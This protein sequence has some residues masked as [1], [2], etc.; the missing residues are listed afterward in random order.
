M[1][2]VKSKNIATRRIP[3]R[4][5]FREKF[6]HKNCVAIGLSAG[7]VEPLEATALLL[8]EAT[9]KLLAEKLPANKAGIDYAQRS[10]NKITH[11]AWEAG[12]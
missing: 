1:L 3:M 4:I 9:A 6:W 7:F 10:F 12:Y 11:Y 8:V 5:G 2:A